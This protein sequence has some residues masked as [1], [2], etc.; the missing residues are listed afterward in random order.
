MTQRYIH[1]FAQFFLETSQRTGTLSVLPS[2]YIVLEEI[3][4]ALVGVTV[5]AKI[6]VSLGTYASRPKYFAY[7]GQ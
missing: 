6:A 2:T 5:D 4:P 7:L 3:N 1:R